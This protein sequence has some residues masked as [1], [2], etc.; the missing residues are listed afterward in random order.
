MVFNFNNYII[1]FF[2]GMVKNQKLSANIL[3]PTTKAVDHDVP[4]TPDEVCC[5]SYIYFWEIYMFMVIYCSILLMFWSFQIVNLGLMTKDEYE[6][7]RNK[8]L[9]LFSYGQVIALFFSI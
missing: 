5:V 7:T 8:A 1:L 4:V 6:E 9:S 2:L 3:T